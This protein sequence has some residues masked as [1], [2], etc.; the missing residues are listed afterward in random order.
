MDI[1]NNFV[2][3]MLLKTDYSSVQGI[4]LAIESD[5]NSDSPRLVFTRGTWNG[6]LNVEAASTHLRENGFSYFVSDKPVEQRNEHTQPRRR[7]DESPSNTGTSVRSAPE[8]RDPVGRREG[9]GSARDQDDRV[10]EHEDTRKGDDRGE[11]HKPSSSGSSGQDAKPGDSDGGGSSDSNSGGGDQSDENGKGGILLE[12]VIIRPEDYTDPTLD[13]IDPIPNEPRRP[14]L[15]TFATPAE[16]GYV[17]QHG[18]AQQQHFEDLTKQLRNAFGRVPIRVGGVPIELIARFAPDFVDPVKFEPPRLDPQQSSGGKPIGTI[19][20]PVEPG[21]VPDITLERPEPREGMIGGKPDFTIVNP[22]EVEGASEEETVDLLERILKA[23][24]KPYQLPEVN[25]DQV[26]QEI[27]ARRQQAYE[28]ARLLS[29]GNPNSLVPVL[30]VSE[31]LVSVQHM[32]RI[33]EFLGWMGGNPSAYANA[34][35]AKNELIDT[36]ET[37]L[38]IYF[39]SL[40]I[41][42]AGV[43][44]LINISHFLDYWTFTRKYNVPT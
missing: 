2:G 20:T 17:P 26:E 14:P 12:T 5:L 36:D 40:A 29:F 28:F 34:I 24:P 15:Y 11:A 7:R 37:G 30:E 32:P 21:T 18:D 38:D 41:S 44:H 33:S 35:A 16:P 27:A 8:N 13:T 9:L 23:T 4:L 39:L 10:R 1:R 19:A 25:L 31:K 43:D 22:T 6:H 3:S 42:D